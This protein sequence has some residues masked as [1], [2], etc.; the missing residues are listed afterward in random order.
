MTRSF[1][2]FLLIVCGL[3]VLCGAAQCKVVTLKVNSLPDFSSQ[4]AD[5]K[6]ESAVVRRFLE[7]HPNVRLVK[8]AGLQM[9]GKTMEVVPLMQIA[10]DISPQVIYVNFRFSDTYIQKGFLKPLDEYMKAMS[11]EEIDRRVPPSM[12]GVC[13][14]KGPDGRMHWYALPTDKVIRALVYRRDLFAKAGLDPNKPPKTWSELEEYCKKLADPAKARYGMGFIKGQTSAYDFQ[15][16]VWS[17][18]GDVVVLDKNG[19]WQPNFNTVE[20]ID[21]LYFYV[22][23]V[24]MRVRGSDGKMYRGVASRDVSLGIIEPL[25]PIAMSLYSLDERLNIYQPDMLAFAAYPHADN[26]EKGRSE[27]NSRMLGVFAGTKDSELAKA[28]FDYIAFLDSD[29]ANSIRARIYVQRGY[30]RFV[31]PQVLKRFGYTDYLKQVDKEWIKVY[32]DV[33][34]NGRPEPYGKNCS[35]IYTELSRPVEQAV[36]DRAV[37]AAIDRGDEAGCKVRLKQ[38][39]DRAQAET[40]KRM[41]NRLPENV[42]ASRHRMTVLFLVCALIGFGVAVGAIVKVFKREAPPQTPGQK[43]QFFAYLLIFPAAASI[44][45]WQYYPLIRGT[46]IAFQDYSVMGGSSFVGIENFSTVLFDSSF[47]YSVYVTL[48]YTALFMASGF[49]AP[50]ILAMML[51]EVPSGKI[52]YRT[53]YYVP[54]VLSG[55]VVMFLWKSFYKPAGLL[56]SLLSFIGINMNTSW[57]D[58]PYLAMLAVILPVI[59][60]GAGPGCLIYLAALKTI[61][62]ELYEAAD[63]DGAGMLRKIWSITLPGLKMLILINAVGAFI[64]A[65]M[66]SESILVMTGG[67]PYTP[68]GATEVVG[69]QLFY[70]AFMYLKFGVANAM[71]WVLGFMLI[72]F[73]LF[74][75]RNLSRVEFKGGR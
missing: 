42:R 71:A 72:G 26:V 21:A 24:N 34:T 12:R 43:K 15:N 74:Q 22:K 53:I 62:E 75:L 6:A 25:D 55:L 20:A 46:V 18:G 1:S 67:G 33:M 10:G 32:E 17:R 66:S 13:Y 61:P 23:L 35:V 4:E 44:L 41:Y 40:Q 69:L 37:I 68:N 19:E 14:R 29:E 63:V 50:I 3:L 58:S 28:A 49:V 51:H 27:I 65:F 5:A 11:Q 57:L 7:L 8:G 39:L 38:I 56:N 73:T 47:W 16:L 54:A 45:V 64:G 52:L 30:G 70:T 48:I 59:W 60:A 9:E 36:Y 31:N 2:T